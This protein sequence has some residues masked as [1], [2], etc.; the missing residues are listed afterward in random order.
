MGTAKASSNQVSY[1]GKKGF[2]FFFP[3]PD[4]ILFLFKANPGT[5]KLLLP[6]WPM[7][8]LPASHFGIG[9]KPSRVSG[10]RARWRGAFTSRPRHLV[11][12]YFMLRG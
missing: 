4:F 11:I 1:W 9:S 3:T 10:G 2:F 7:S 12:A 5:R 8:L 6:E